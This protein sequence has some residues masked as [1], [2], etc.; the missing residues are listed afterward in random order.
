MNI[1]KDLVVIRFLQICRFDQGF[2]P[3]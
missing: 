2:R 3:C 1:S